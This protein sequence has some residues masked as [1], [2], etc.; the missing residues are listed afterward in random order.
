M[1]SAFFLFPHCRSLHG[2]RT[3]SKQVLTEWWRVRGSFFTRRRFPQ[4]YCLMRIR[5]GRLRI[6][7][8]LYRGGCQNGPVFPISSRVATVSWKYSRL[9][10]SQSSSRRLRKNFPEKS[11]NTSSRGMIPSVAVGLNCDQFL[12]CSSDRKRFMVLQVY[13]QS[14][15]HFLKGT[16]T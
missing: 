9:R 8:V 12:M 14:S 2:T 13:A 1:A 5:T 16:A 10:A 4:S 6:R 15:I 3:C 11:L 7:P